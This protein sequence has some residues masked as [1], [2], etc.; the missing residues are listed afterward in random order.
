[1]KPQKITEL[2]KIGNYMVLKLANGE[3]IGMTM[4]GYIDMLES[5]EEHLD[6]DFSVEV[7][8]NDLIGCNA[9]SDGMTVTI[10]WGTE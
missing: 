10:E 5:R 3:S 7:T 2:E 8:G 1:M 6:P 4:G 9:S